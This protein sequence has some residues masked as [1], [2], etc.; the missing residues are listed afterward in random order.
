M[1]ANRDGS[2]I[3]GYVALGDGSGID[4]AL[5]WTAAGGSEL[6]GHL[7]GDLMSWGEGVSGDGR[8]VVGQSTPSWDMPEGRATYWTREVGLVDLNTY[9][10]LLGA[11][12]TGWVLEDAPAIS[13]DGLTIAG[14]GLHVGQYEAWIAK[15]SRCGSADFNGDGSLG[16]DAD[17]AAFFAC[18]GG[19]CC[20]SCGSV[21]FNGDH[22][23][24]TD[25]DIEAFFRVLSGGSC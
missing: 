8:I 14:M 10:P 17:I 5:R 11:D 2:V 20:P 21:D 1:A 15:F 12:L 18:L 19:N 22:D 3:V 6:L 13:A 9:L 7:P 25:A 23:V 4:T 24:G 16:T